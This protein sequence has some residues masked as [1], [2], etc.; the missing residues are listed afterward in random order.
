[1]TP[2]QTKTPEFSIIVPSR[3][4]PGLVRRAVNSVL[5]QNHTAL[6]VIVVNDGSDAEHEASYD[7][8]RAL[9]DRVR[10]LTLQRTPN[11]HGPS[12]AINRGADAA[13]GRF[14]G[15]L[16]DDDTWIDR[17]HLERVAQAH[18]E[19]PALDLYLC[20]QEAV[21]G[22]APVTDALWL[23]GLAEH[24]EQRRAPNAR[25]E[26]P[27]VLDELL[28]CPTFAHLNTMIVRRQ[29]YADCGAMD[30]SIRYECE[31][32][33]YFRFLEHARE[34]LFFPGRI[35]RHYVP[36]PT[37]RANASTVVSSLQKLSLRNRVMDKTLLFCESPAIRRRAGQVK[38]MTLKRLSQAMAAEGKWS[39]GF[40]YASEALVP[41]FNFKWL[42]YWG[43]LGCRVL[44]SREH[45]E[46]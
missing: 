16:D 14:I 42:G 27:V 18:Q 1:M 33:L 28:I 17:S 30:E 45:H 12:Y 39:Q 20:C 43:Y 15:F 9:D 34:I 4:R 41:G 29:V 46:D 24:L 35:A 40:R 32:D 36:D 10:L 7:A 8:L 37:Q 44:V 11:G 2:E 3:N 25:G 23:N 38:S 19:Q 6:E 26:Y 21:R 22:E 13:R 5:E 31:W